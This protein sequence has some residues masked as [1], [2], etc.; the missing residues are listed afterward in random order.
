MLIL[1]ILV[2]ASVQS[3]D[4]KL[5]HPE[6]PDRPKQNAHRQHDPEQIKTA[7]RFHRW[8]VISHHA[9]PDGESVAEYR[10]ALFQSAPGSPGVFAR[11][12]SGN[13]VIWLHRKVHSCHPT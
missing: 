4:E 12:A 10:S 3:D 8:Y 13:D 2:V 11:H 6:N 5:R 9:H 7:S 1:V